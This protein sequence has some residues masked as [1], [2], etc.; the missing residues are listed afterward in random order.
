[1]KHDYLWDRS[2]PPDAEVK[3]LE[4]L[5]GALRATE[6]PAPR[7][8]RGYWRQALAASLLAAAAVSQILLTSPPASSWQM[9]GEE[10]HTGQVVRSS[11][12]APR[13]EADAVG[14]IELEPN[15]ELAIA[16]SR[17]GRQRLD[18]R[19][20]TLHALIW[21]PA[22]E[23]VV[24]TPSARAIDLGCQ[25]TL[26]VNPG[27]DGQLKVLTGWVA[28]QHRGLESFIPA[29]AACRTRRLAGPGTPY[30]EDAPAGLVAA[31]AEYDA[32]RTPAA[33][34]AVLQAARPRD[35]IT[36]WHLLSRASGSGRA[37]VFRAFSR[38]VR[39]PAEVTEARIARPDAAALDLCW[40]ALGL[41]SAEWYRTWQRPWK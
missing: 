19:R 15:S 35:A 12:S 13:M 5:L 22:R 14:R 38:L 28:F 1:M 34:E 16:E 7:Q 10:L 29:G 33:L 17:P 31:L 32:R 2:G 23:F 18:L 40:N 39:V 9:A 36:P 26:T 21:A 41:D 6:Q 3:R 8:G 20:G 30:F 24:D 25:Y 4:D 37:E 11:A 27:G